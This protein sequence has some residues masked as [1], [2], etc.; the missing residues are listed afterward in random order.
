MTNE[1]FDHIIN[2][3][4]HEYDATVSAKL[5]NKIH[6]AIP[7][8]STDLSFDSFVK[9]QLANLIAPVPAGLWDKVKPVQEKRRRLFFFIPRTSMI[10]A[11]IIALVLAGSISAYLYYQKI[12]STEI[13]SASRSENSLSVSNIAKWKKKSTA[14]SLVLKEA[15]SELPNN[16]K[17]ATESVL[18]NTKKKSSSTILNSTAGINISTQTSNKQFRKE[19]NNNSTFIIKPTK[20]EAVV[21]FM[22]TKLPLPENIE[23]EASFL[24]SEKAGNVFI[25]RKRILYNAFVKKTIPNFNESG[26]LKNIIICPSD[27]KLH[28]TDWDFELYFGPDYATKSITNYSASEQFLSRKDSSETAGISYSVG[29]RIGKPINN[30]F[31]IKSGLNFSQ[32]NEKFSYRTENEI[33][34]TT[35]V[36]QRV[37]IRAP[38]DTTIISDTSTLQ[39]I[40]FKNNQVKNRYR[41]IDLPILF[42]YQFGNEDFK[43]GLTAGVILNLTSWYQGMIFDSSLTLLNISKPTEMVHKKN[44]GLGL[45]A[46]VSFAKRLNY[47]TQIFAEPYI[48]FNLSDMN[49]PG[50]AYKQKFSV[51]GLSLGVRFN[52]NKR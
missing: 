28:N 40:G 9:D 20:K 29:F 37:I 10:A 21:N 44:I 32:I 4:L 30:H 17:L 5:W 36:T 38:G 14:T 48:R 43:I 41:S 49:R 8:A 51:G 18:V 24:T 52:L 12:H 19:S 2:Q 7:V 6:S 42:G 22:Q 35:V 45:Y 47:S 34:T 11:S 1:E 50:A 39:Q 3:K 46:G 31:S 25:V 33:R 15:K 16:E 13:F 27:K 26:K 23:T